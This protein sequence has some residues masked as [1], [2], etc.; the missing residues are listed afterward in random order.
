MTMIDPKTENVMTFP[1]VVTA[2]L[3]AEHGKTEDE[4]S[5]LVKTHTNIVVNG[6]MANNYRSTAM[7][8]VMEES[9]ST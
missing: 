7:A 4:A 8:L 1:E 5:H 2:M 9:K 6:I 3:V